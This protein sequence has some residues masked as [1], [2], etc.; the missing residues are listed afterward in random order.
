MM[1]IDMRSATPEEQARHRAAIDEIKQLFPDLPDDEI[2]TLL[3]NCTPYPAVAVPECL[4]GLRTLAAT[5]KGSWE[6]ALR[7]SD[8]DFHRAMEGFSKHAVSGPVHL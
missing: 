4:T 7:L 1:N 8:E 5:A 3:M 2:A 6:E